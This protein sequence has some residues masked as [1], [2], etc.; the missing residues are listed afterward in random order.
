MP[1]FLSTINVAFWWSS[2]LQTRIDSMNLFNHRRHL[3]PQYPHCDSNAQLFVDNN[4]HSTILQKRNL[5]KGNDLGLK[6]AL[7]L[8]FI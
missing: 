8:D 4:L 3:H 5:N 1:G 2:C 6:P 7:A